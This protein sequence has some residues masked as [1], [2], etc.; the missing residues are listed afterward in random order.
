[1]ATV[2]LANSASLIALSTLT[3]TAVLA[4]AHKPW[5]QERDAKASRVASFEHQVTGVTVAENGRIFVNFPRWTEDAPISVAE[6]TRDG[7]VQPYPNEEW[8]A[9]RNSKKFQISPRDH[10]V[11][12]GRRPR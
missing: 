3:G 5:A 9:W 8:N 1:M 6:L 10:F 4:I 2:K 11:C 7:S 12:I